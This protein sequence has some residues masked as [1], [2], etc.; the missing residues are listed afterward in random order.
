MADRRSREL[1][2]GRAAVGYRVAHAAFAVVQLASLGY[3]WGCALTGRRDR[4]LR[5]AVGLLGAEGAA[6]IVGR[7][8]CPLGPFQARL[9]DPVPLFELVLPPRAAK[10]AI[11]V[12]A[13][14]AV[15]GI[16]ALLI[17]PRAETPRVVA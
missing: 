5:A 6:L 9:G 13:A 7:G 11:P 8:N 10:A 4:L 17:L 1:G 14:V 3:V 16:A 12:L 2:L 15:A